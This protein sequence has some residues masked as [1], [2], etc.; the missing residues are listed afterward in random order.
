MALWG[1]TIANDD[2]P[3][4]LTSDQ[5][6]NTTLTESGWVYTHLNGNEEL[7]VALGDAEPGPINTVLPVITG[8]VEVGE[9]LTTTNGT[10]VGGSPTYA[11]MWQGSEDGVVW[12]DLGSNSTTYVP[13]PGDVDKYIRVRVTA[14]LN[15][16]STTVYSE[17][18]GPVVA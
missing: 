1:K 2:K 17:T 6:D 15:G 3:K 9:S 18:V 16:Y 8:T 4:W 14:T 12:S 10:W 7:L 5:K 11:R 13:L